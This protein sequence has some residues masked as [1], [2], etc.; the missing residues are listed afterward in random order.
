MDQAKIKRLE[1]KGWKVGNTA[2]FLELNPEENAFIELKLA[3]SKH[4]KELRISQ[5][6]SQEEL[7]KKIKSSQS[8]VAKMEDCDPSVSLDLIIKTILSLGSSNQDIAQ[9]IV[10][11][12]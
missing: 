8:R 10:N 6:F 3:L 9:V 5:N 2:D 11:S 4:L 7:A 12:Q 1:A